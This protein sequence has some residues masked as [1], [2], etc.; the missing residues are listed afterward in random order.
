[1]TINTIDYCL[2]N[3]LDLLQQYSVISYKNGEYYG[4]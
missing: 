4:A 1:M 2:A 3:S